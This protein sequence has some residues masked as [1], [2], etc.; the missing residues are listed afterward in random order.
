MIILMMINNDTI[1]SLKKIDLKNLKHL[2][3]E[4]ERQRKTE[5]SFKKKHLNYFLENIYS[6]MNKI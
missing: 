6:K 5:K 1:W 3:L 4:R 2:C